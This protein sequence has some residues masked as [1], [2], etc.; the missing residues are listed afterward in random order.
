MCVWLWVFCEEALSSDSIVSEEK[1]V[2]PLSPSPSHLE[3]Q[4]HTQDT[5]HTL[6]VN[7]APPPHATVGV[8]ILI[9]V[10]AGWVAHRG[11]SGARRRPALAQLLCCNWE[12]WGVCTCTGK[13]GPFKGWRHFSKRTGTLASAVSRHP[14]ISLNCF[15]SVRV[16]AWLNH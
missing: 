11:L 14:L 7:S 1:Q 9:P 8:Q 5:A 4:P 15:G 2:A 12:Q 10:S 13:L 16:L 3:T 6:R